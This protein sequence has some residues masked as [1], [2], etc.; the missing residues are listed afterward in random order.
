M[1]GEN[2]GKA[3]GERVGRGKKG[4]RK[5]VGSEEREGEGSAKGV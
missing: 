1:E 3:E 5:G 2:G 4:I